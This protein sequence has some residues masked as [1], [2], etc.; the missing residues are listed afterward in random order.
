MILKEQ[1]DHDPTI[2]RKTF[3]HLVHS[4]RTFIISGLVRDDHFSDT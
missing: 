2:P 3:D 1:E 4:Y